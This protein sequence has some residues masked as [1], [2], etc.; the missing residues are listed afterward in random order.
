MLHVDHADDFLFGH[1]RHRNEGLMPIFRK[2]MKKFEA[3]IVARI[4]G[5]DDARPFLRHP[6][7]NAFPQPD[8]DA[9]DQF[10]MRILRSSKNEF[11]LAVRQEI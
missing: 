2:V 1:D 9:S 5:N 6:P 11:V 10:G 3:G 7:R 8:R 4:T